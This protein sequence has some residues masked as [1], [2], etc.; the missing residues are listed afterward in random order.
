MRKNLLMILLILG[1]ASVVT[2]IALRFSR[3]RQSIWVRPHI[4]GIV[5][6]SV[7][8]TIISNA[9]ITAISGA[10]EF[11][12]KSDSTGRFEIPGEQKDHWVTPGYLMFLT[13]VWIEKTGYISKGEQFSVTSHDDMD[14]PVAPVKDLII[15]L[16]PRSNESKGNEREDTKERW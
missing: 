14:S 1:F 9:K 10:N 16:V 5:L 2:T 12:C 15:E 11:V 7:T 13:D 8:Q 3:V 6:D 4:K